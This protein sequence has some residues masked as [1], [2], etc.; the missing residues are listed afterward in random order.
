MRYIMLYRCSQ[1]RSQQVLSILRSPPS[2]EVQTEAMWLQKAIPQVA[3]ATA[4]PRC[5]EKKFQDHIRPL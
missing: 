4:I 5:F 2:Q 1:K 3:A